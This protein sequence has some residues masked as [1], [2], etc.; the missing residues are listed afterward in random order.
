MTRICVRWMTSLCSHWLKVYC[1]VV[2]LINNDSLY[3]V[4]VFFLIHKKKR[5]DKGEIK[6]SAVEWTMMMSIWLLVPVRPYKVFLEHVPN[7]T[8]ETFSSWHF[9]S[10]LQNSNWTPKMWSR[11]RVNKPSSNIPPAWTKWIGE[12]LIT[13]I[14]R[15]ANSNN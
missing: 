13:T 6:E 4:E 2:C 7:K 5:F 12:F 14:C 9:S 8:M 1:C 10:R 15:H 11:W 3:W